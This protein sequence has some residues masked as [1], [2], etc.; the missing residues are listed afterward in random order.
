M[1]RGEGFRNHEGCIYPVYFKPL[2]Q[3][4]YQNPIKEEFKDITDEMVSGIYPW[5][6]ISNYGRIWHKYLGQFLNINIDSKGYSYKP[7]ATINGAKVERVHRLVLMAF[8]PR[9]NSNELVV[10]HIDG[11]KC[12]NII[13]NLEWTTYSGNTIH[14]Y[15]NGLMPR[16][17][18]SKYDDPVLIHSI[19]QDIQNGISSQDISN[20][21]NIPID[22]VD[23][24]KYKKAHREISDQYTFQVTKYRTQLTEEQIKMICE[25]F[26]INPK[27][28]NT[29][30][31]YY[32]ALKSIGI[33]NPEFNLVLSVQRIYT[34]RLFKNI[35]DNYKW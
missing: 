22:L 6:C 18:A 10:N 7:L 3:I 35:S 21:Y 8:D 28:D 23:S 20:K 13:T 33:N 2:D 17:H 15:N 25:Y 32:D 29:R 12:N 19:C 31:I 30:K 11:N 27:M 5:Y 24:I 34:R 4:I 14:A 16:T 9:P 26:S 1:K